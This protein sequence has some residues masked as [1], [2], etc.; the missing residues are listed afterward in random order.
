M[1]PYDDVAMN[2]IR[3]TSMNEADPGSHTQTTIDDLL[4]VLSIRYTLSLR[5]F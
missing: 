3:L 5:R 4:S 2:G 1:N